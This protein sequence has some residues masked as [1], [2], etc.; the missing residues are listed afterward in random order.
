MLILQLQI[1]ISLKSNSSLLYQKL[2]KYLEDN[3]LSIYFELLQP[4]K[5]LDINETLLI[6]PQSINSIRIYKTYTS[7]NVGVC[8]L[9]LLP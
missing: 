1:Y 3:N 7:H 5:H 4:M 9:K 2:V 6:G 8:Y